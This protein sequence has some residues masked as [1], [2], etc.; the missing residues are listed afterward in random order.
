[1]MPLKVQYYMSYCQFQ[2]CLKKKI[3][4]LQCYM[5]QRSSLAA[6]RIM[7]SALDHIPAKGTAGVAESARS[8]TSILPLEASWNGVLAKHTTR[9][10][11]SMRPTA[12]WSLWEVYARRN[13]TQSWQKWI[14]V[15]TAKQTPNDLFCFCLWVGDFCSVNFSIS[16]K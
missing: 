4:I 6:P 7:W 16:H 9:S 12:W 8:G 1:M 15:V 13:V 14:L 3:K 2:I 11:K 10:I 5:I